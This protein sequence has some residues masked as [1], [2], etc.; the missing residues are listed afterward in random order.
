MQNKNRHYMA[1][2]VGGCRIH[3][4]PEQNREPWMCHGLLPGT[5][6]WW[7]RM[8]R[9]CR[10]RFPHQRLESKP[11]VN[12]PGMRHGTF[13]THVPWCISGSLTRVGGETI[14]GIAGACATHHFTY[15]IRVPLQMYSVHHY[16]IAGF[17]TFNASD[18]HSHSAEIIYTAN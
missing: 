14:P 6:N 13:V 18:I 16:D 5:W 3:N 9:E 1:L 7:L 2:A 10:E 11:L 17:L 4:K 8:R 15:L 12:D